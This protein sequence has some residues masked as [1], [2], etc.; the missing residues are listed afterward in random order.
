VKDSDKLRRKMSILATREKRQYQ[1]CKVFS[2]KIDASHLSKEKENYL[3]RIFLEGKWYYNYILSCEDVFTFDAKQTIVNILNKD[4]QLE[5]RIIK[6][7]TAQMR[8]DIKTRIMSSIK[9]LATKKRNGKANQVGRLKFKSVCNSI[10][11]RQS[12]MTYRFEN[13]KYIFIQGFKK[14]FKIL[15]F[16]QIPQNAELANAQLIRRASGYYIQAICF[17]PK[18]EKLIT[19]NFIGLDFG[20]KDSIVDSNGNKYNFQFPESKAIKLASRKF[21]K[22]KNGTAK[23]KK[24]YKQ[25][26]IATEKHENKKQDIKNK[27]VSALVKSND[28]VA[29]QDENLKAWHS[30]AMKGFSRRVQ[31]SIMG[32]IKSGLRRHPETL[33][34]DRFFP[35]TQLCPECGSLNKHGLK[36]REYKCSCGYSCDRDTHSARNILNEGLRKLGREPIKMSDEKKSS[37][38]ENFIFDNKKVFV[39]SGSQRALAVGS[40]L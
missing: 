3:K 24:A 17:T 12:G 23:R 30:S 34:I 15:G 9:G 28:I 5:E 36:E 16:N 4:K 35:S 7:L 21:N 14:H 27:F 37:V 31:H 29:I 25:L 40:S 10:P 11:L 8:A 13:G 38:I 6:H 33:M 20:I 19:N 39:D 2:L 1:D 32:G 18:T 22:S 26:T